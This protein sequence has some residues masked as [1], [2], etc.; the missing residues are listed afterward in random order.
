MLYVREQD[1]LSLY[2]QN[3]II[4]VLSILLTNPVFGLDTIKIPT[5]VLQTTINGTVTN[6]QNGQQGPATI[7]GLPSFLSTKKN[8]DPTRRAQQQKYLLKS[9]MVNVKHGLSA[10]VIGPEDDELG[11]G[12]PLLLLSSAAFSR[13]HL[14]DRAYLFCIDLI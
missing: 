5:N 10:S 2:T 8:I 12:S 9:S 4:Q 13:S 3:T 14:T 6:V 11:G 7:I 1:N